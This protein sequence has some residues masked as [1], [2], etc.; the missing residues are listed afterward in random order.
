MEKWQEYIHSDPAIMLGKPVIKGTRIT[1]ELIVERL[2]YGQSLEELL[3]SYPHLTREGIL[4]CLQYAAGTL[5]NENNHPLW[6]AV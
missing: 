3:V 6:L 4:S 2:G 5:N 1:V